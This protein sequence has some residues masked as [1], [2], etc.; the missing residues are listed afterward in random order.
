MVIGED[1]T[2]GLSL[3]MVNLSREVNIF[4][5]SVNPLSQFTAVLASASAKSG[6]DQASSVSAKYKSLRN[7]RQT[8]K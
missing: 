5:L 1:K 8:N 6:D 2:S 4:E 7:S 3:D